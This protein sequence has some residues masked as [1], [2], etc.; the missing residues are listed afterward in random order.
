MWRGVGHTVRSHLSDSRLGRTSHSDVKSISLSGPH[1]L[2]AL[3]PWAAETTGWGVGRE[4][5][6]GL[7]QRKFTTENT[8]STPTEWDN[9]DRGQRPGRL[10]V[11]DVRR[12]PLSTTPLSACPP[13]PHTPLATPPPPAL[14]TV[15]G[16]PLGGS[17]GA[18]M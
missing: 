1:I 8:N 5:H 10:R 15:G 13:S 17:I 11:P 16:P 6:S 4:T 3:P 18:L 2:V 9:G 14:A 12:P 7:E